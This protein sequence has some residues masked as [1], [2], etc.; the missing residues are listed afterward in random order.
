MQ[1]LDLIVGILRVVD[2]TFKTLVLMLR[3]PLLDSG[4]SQ[5]GSLD[6]GQYDIQWISCE[7]LM[8]R[9]CEPM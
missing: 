1:S 5:T 7:L 8:E 3:L 9:S 2:F 4:R 6:S